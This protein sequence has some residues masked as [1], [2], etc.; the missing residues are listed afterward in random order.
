[1]ETS[2]PIKKLR[3]KT[4][5]LS[6]ILCCVAFGT[7][8]ALILAC[9]ALNDGLTT[10]K[11]SFT[12]N[13]TAIRDSSS[14]S[15]VKSEVNLVDISITFTS[16]ST[17]LMGSRVSIGSIPSKYTDKVDL[18]DMFTSTN[19]QEY[20]IATLKTD[21]TIQLSLCC[22]NFTSGNS[23]QIHYAFYQK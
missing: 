1:M 6:I 7:L 12:P 8:L 16:A 3:T 14:S 20:G 21:G 4:T 13:T 15:I 2:K 23:F 22:S 18:S 11:I 19:S 9:V 10:T 17:V 5:V